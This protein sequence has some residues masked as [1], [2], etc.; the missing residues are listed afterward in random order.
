MPE[1]LGCT[2]GENGHHIDPLVFL[3]WK[4][5]FHVHVDVSCIPLGAVL[6]HASEGD[7]DHPIAFASR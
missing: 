1:E 2:K 5:E 4:K 7:L 6:T 3:D